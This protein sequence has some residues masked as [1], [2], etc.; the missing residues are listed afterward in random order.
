MRP[1]PRQRVPGVRA[2]E[3]ADEQHFMAARKGGV[4]DR[5]RI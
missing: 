4:A 2:V 1:R 3:E 5:G